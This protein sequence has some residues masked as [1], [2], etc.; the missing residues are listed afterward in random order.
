MNT[1]HS[2][3]YAT[4]IREN[5]A[6]V[7][8]LLQSEAGV[9]NEQAAMSCGLGLTSYRDLK[10]ARRM[11]SL[12]DMVRVTKAFGVP[13]DVFVMP[14]EKVRDAYRTGPGFDLLEPKEIESQDPKRRKGE[15]D[16]GLA[17]MDQFDLP[18]QTKR[19]IATN[20]TPKSDRWVA[21]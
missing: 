3:G 4:A 11:M 1:T 19:A 12:L 8:K 9:T 6:D 13:L 17:P 15:A 20:L 10:G 14:L 5:A 21:A 2:N 16:D 18:L 7:V